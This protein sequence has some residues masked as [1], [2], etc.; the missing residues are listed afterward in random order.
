MT[1]TAAHPARPP[2]TEA[3][4]RFAR[5][6]KHF[7]PIDRTRSPA[8]RLARATAHVALL[9]RANARFASPTRTGPRPLHTGAI[10]H[11]A[12]LPRAKE[13][14]ASLARIGTR[15]PFACAAAHVPPRGKMHELVPSGAALPQVSQ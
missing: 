4:P 14:F 8:S 6:T 10:A 5:A 1:P 12:R 7:F 3:G 9:F 11:V 15:P 2:R 13:F